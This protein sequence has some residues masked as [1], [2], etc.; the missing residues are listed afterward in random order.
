MSIRT[1]EGFQRWVR[2]QLAMQGINFRMLSEQMGV[3]PSRVSEALHGKPSGKKYIAP[4][5]KTLGGNVDDFK[6]IM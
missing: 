5:I 3:P 6:A 2:I 4:L 1:R